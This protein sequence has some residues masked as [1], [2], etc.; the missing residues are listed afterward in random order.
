MTRAEL[1]NP[2][3][4][5]ARFGVHNRSGGALAV[6]T[7]PMTVLA[8]VHIELFPSLDIGGCGRYASLRTAGPLSPTHPTMMPTPSM[9]ASV[10]GLL[11]IRRMLSVHS[12]YLV[13]TAATFLHDARL[14]P[15]RLI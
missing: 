9:N 1:I 14:V 11:H 10:A 5:I 8:A 12:L 2:G 7:F 15:G 3:R 6:A 4:E 13:P